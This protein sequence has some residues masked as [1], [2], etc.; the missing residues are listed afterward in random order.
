MCDE[1][2]LTQPLDKQATQI[3]HL[4]QD[5]DE[6]KREFTEQVDYLRR[7]IDQIERRTS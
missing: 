7:R 2:V 3:E 5:L 6:L 1:E 4:Q